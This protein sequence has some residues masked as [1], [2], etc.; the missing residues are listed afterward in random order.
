[1]KLAW[2]QAAKTPGSAYGGVVVKDGKV[3]ASDHH[4]VLEGPDLSAHAEMS[5]MRAANK[6]LN[7]YSLKGC[8]LYST[9][10]PCEMCVAAAEWAGVDEIVYAKTKAEDPDPHEISKITIEDYVKALGLKIK[11]RKFDS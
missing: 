10:S 9:Y 6:A 4:H 2:Q 3:V 1:M 7:S 8:T 5:A 11:I